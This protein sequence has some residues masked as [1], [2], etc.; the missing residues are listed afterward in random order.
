MTSNFF[1]SIPEPKQEYREIT[2]QWLPL[3]FYSLKEVSDIQNKAI[4]YDFDTYTLLEEIPK[5]T[6]FYN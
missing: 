6:H 1:D 5:E 4:R 2:Y 3:E